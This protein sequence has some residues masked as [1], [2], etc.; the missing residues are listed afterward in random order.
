MGCTRE[1][2]PARL[3]EGCL[4]RRLHLRNGPYIEGGP[5]ES[6]QRAKLTSCQ[7][8]MHFLGWRGWLKVRD[9]YKRKTGSSYSVAAFH[10]SAIKEGAVPLPVLAGLLK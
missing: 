2:P 3:P 1:R 10:D 4:S 8:P 6:L 7:L 5:A 9:D